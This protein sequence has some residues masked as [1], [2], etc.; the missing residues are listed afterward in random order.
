MDKK[1]YE[2]SGEKFAI[3]L[4]TKVKKLALWKKSFCIL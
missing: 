4:T 2:Q 3:L 1:Q